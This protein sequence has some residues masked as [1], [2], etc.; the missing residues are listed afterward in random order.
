MKIPFIEQIIYFFTKPSKFEL[1]S[2]FSELSAYTSGSVPINQ[3]LAATANYQSNKH[4]QAALKDIERDLIRG[5]DISTAFYKQKIFDHSVAPS[6]KAGEMSAQLEKVFAN[7]AENYWQQ[8]EVQEKI[9]DA[10]RTPKMGFIIMFFGC[11]AFAKFA[12]PK[13]EALYQKN[14]IELPTLITFFSRSVNFLTENIVLL[15]LATILLCKLYKHFTDRNPCVVDKILLKTPVFGQL[16]YT[17]LQQAFSQNLSV[18]VASGLDIKRA[19]ELIAQMVASPVMSRQLEKAAAAMSNGMDITKAFQSINTE[20]IIHP[21]TISFI[22]SGE[23]TS[24]LDQ[25]LKQAAQVHEANLRLLAKK[26]ESRLTIAALL[27][28]VALIL[29]FY[30]MSI[31]PATKLLTQMPGG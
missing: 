15:L 14:N 4:L 26:A 22:N 31:M 17:Q 25:M 7:L 12:I 21:K 28:L 29:T 20:K 10:L 6:I 9:D 5:S 2:L 13:Y 24:R 27:P 30:Y 3:A 19:T 11:I 1:F 8:A 16:Y 23:N 18:L